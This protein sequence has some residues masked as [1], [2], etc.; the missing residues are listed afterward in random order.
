MVDIIEEKNTSFFG[1]YE[2]KYFFFSLHY[3]LTRI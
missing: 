3:Q 1:E 2:V